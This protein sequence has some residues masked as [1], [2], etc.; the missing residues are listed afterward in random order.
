M[1]TSSM[2]YKIEQKAVRRIWL[3]NQLKVIWRKVLY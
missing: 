2:N 1:L 3:L